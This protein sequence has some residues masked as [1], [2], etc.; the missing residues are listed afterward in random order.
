MKT[1]R[2][3]YTIAN[4]LLLALALLLVLAM[5]S[6]M[7]YKRAVRKYAHMA[8]DSVEVTTTVPIVIHDTLTIPGDTVTLSVQTDTTYL[9]K[10]VEG[11][12]AKL[13]FER[14]KGL[15]RLTAEAKPD[16]VIRVISRTKTIRQKCPPVAQFGV[17]AWYRVGFF[18]ALALLVLTLLFVLFTYIFRISIARR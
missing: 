18:V 8:K 3:G 16:T 9:Y 11:K 6:C 13:T 14:S 17:A 4:I 7:T 12:R 15:T 2:I 5:N 1:E 10:V